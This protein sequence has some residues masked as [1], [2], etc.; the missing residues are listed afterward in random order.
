M[1][2][3]R[4]PGERA[5][6]V[7]RA[8]RTPKHPTS[9]DDI[10]VPVHVPQIKTP[11]PAIFPAKLRLV[12]QRYLDTEPRS[13]SKA[14]Q[15]AGMEMSELNAYL[16][17]QSIRDYIKAQEDLIDEKT[18]ELRALARVLTQDHLDSETV[19]ILESASTPVNAKVR[20]I[21][22]GYRRFG[23][24]KDKVE[25]TGAGGAPLAFQLVRIGQKPPNTDKGE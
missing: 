23:M 9:P 24:L 13:Y 2:F 22:V 1:P 6:G 18:A 21:E 8:P 4:K 15:Q 10:R 12:I 25:A 14:A 3:R 11:D 17:Q 5:A 7:P 19:K 16:K 20:M